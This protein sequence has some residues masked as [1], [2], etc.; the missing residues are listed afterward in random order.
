MT[1]LL[2][3]LAQ[4]RKGATAIEYGLIAAFIALAIVGALPGIRDNLSGTFGTIK[5]NLQSSSTQG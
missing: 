3:K 2:N 4:D 5:N 1:K